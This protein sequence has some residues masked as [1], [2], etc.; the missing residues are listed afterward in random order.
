MNKFFLEEYKKVR[1]IG[2]IFWMR[3][4][5]LAEHVQS[6]GFKDVQSVVIPS[7]KEL[8]YIHAVSEGIE[9]DITDYCHEHKL[10]GSEYS[11][12]MLLLKPWIAALAEYIEHMKVDFNPKMASDLF[13]NSESMSIT[14]A[15]AA[16]FKDLNTKLAAKLELLSYK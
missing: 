2:N 1:S 7:L 15:D 11:G 10:S 5:H 16:K 9:H 12:I 4:E 13:K 8:S 6:N 14:N 3:Y